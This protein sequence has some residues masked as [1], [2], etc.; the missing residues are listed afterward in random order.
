MPKAFLS[1]S[2]KDKKS[3]TNIVAEK[4]GKFNCIYD[5]YTFEEGFK[6]IEEIERGL[7]KTDLFVLFI[8]DTSLNSDWVKKELNKAHKLLKSGNIKRLYPIIIDPKILYDDPRIPRWMTEYNLKLIAQPVVAARRIKQRL[9]ELS[10]NFH[11]KLKERQKIFVGRN[12]LIKAFEERIDSLEQPVPKCI[13]ASGLLNI[14]RKALI[15]HCLIKSNLI[16][17]SHELP[18][19]TLNSH[20]SVEDFINKIYDLGYSGKTDITGMMTKNID[21]KLKVCQQLIDDL[22]K[23]REIILVEDNG[24]IVTP[25]NNLS[26]WF[27]K[28]LWIYAEIEQT[29]FIVASRFRL[30]QVHKLKNIAY[31]VEVP[32]L[33]KKERDGLLKRYAT[34]QELQLTNEDFNFISDLLKG[35]PEQIFFVVDL[36]KERGIEYVKNH[37]YLIIEYNSE[38]VNHI[39]QMYENDDLTMEFLKF[40]SEFEFISFN[41]IF[42]I[43]GE[44]SKFIKLIEDFLSRAICEQLGANKEYIRVNYAIRDY[45][46]RKKINISNEYITKMNDHLK[47]FLKD[48]K[49]EERDL[50]DFLYSMKEALRLGHSINNKYL[51]PSHFLKTMIELYDK[52]QKYDEVVKLADRVLQNSQYLDERIKI[53]IKYFLCLALARLRDKRFMEE[54]QTIKGPEHNFLFGFYYRQIG[55]SLSAIEQ[56]DKALS[57]RPNFSRAKRELVQAYINIEDFENAIELAK[58]NYEHDKNNPYHIHAYFRCIFNSPHNTENTKLLKELLKNLDRIKSE[59]ANEMFLTCSAEFEAFHNNDKNKAFQLINDAIRIYPKVL[60]PKFTKFLICEKFNEFDIMEETIKEI[61][62][63]ITS[64][65]SAMYYRLLWLKVIYFARKNN[66]SEIDNLMQIIAKNYPKDA[67]EKLKQKISQYIKF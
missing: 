56:F 7:Q 50:S 48:Y 42:E 19:I 8:S 31:T 25:E 14:G 39:I 6:S 38:K 43:V 63:E 29:I 53:E 45:I 58:E 52:Y 35:Y 2:S 32:E 3:Y 10:W 22:I 28:I 65:K 33:D 26:D 4:L 12:D 66:K 9:R 41:Y 57:A 62:V 67:V 64:K 30:Y 1:H 34:F 24:C 5:E 23:A 17:D 15:K 11:P 49:N 40:L 61:E 13:V 37:S 44:D 46:R 54:V 59:R 51:I 16:D 60:Y 27:N 20:E 47:V 21:E 36:I 55:N 18:L